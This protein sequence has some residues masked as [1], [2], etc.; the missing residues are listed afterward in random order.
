MQ[1]RLWM[2]LSSITSL[3]QQMSDVTPTDNTICQM[4]TTN[5]LDANLFCRI[6]FF[7]TLHICAMFH[8]QWDNLDQ[9]LTRTLPQGLVDWTI[10]YPSGILTSLHLAALTS[11]KTQ[12]IH[13]SIKVRSNHLLSQNINPKH[14]ALSKTSLPSSIH[15]LRCHL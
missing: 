11:W 6:H 13:D 2:K 9:S 10:T 14:N 7:L 15:W 8:C 1:P 5:V 12:M 3:L 4:T